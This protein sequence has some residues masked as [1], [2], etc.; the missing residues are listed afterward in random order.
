MRNEFKPKGYVIKQWTVLVHETSLSSFK[1]GHVLKGTVPWLT[2][3]TYF[4]SNSNLNYQTHNLRHAMM[5]HKE[6]KLTTAFA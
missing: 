1:V 4:N 6:K 2:R 3:S 5:L